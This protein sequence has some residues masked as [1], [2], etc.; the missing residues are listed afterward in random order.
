MVFLQPRRA[1]LAVEADG[2]RL[3]AGTQRRHLALGAALGR[4]QFGDPFVGQPQRG[5]RAVVMLVE[6]DLTGVEFT[7]AALHRLE[8]GLHLLGLR[9][10]VL[11]AAGQPRH[12]LV[13]RLDAGA[14]RVDL[15]CQ[16][17]QPLT[18]VGLGAGGG[19]VGT[20]GFGGDAL[21]LAQFGAGGL[22]PRSRFGQLVEQLPLLGGDLLGLGLQRVG[23]GTGGGFGLGVE[24]LGSL[25]GDAH[26]GADTFGQRRQ[27]KP[28]LLSGFRALTE[29]ADRRLVGV[30]LD[31]LGLEPGGQIV[32]FAAQRRLGLVGVLELGLAVHQI[33]GGQPQPSVAQVGL[34]GLGAAGHLG[35]PAERLELTAQ[36]GRQVRQPRQVGRHRVELADRLLL[37]LAVLEHPGGFLDERAPVLRAGLEDLG[38]LALA[39]DD[40]HLAADAGVATAAPAH[41]SNGNWCR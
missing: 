39:D 33:V 18:A 40:V 7:D 4:L 22:Q 11:D 14:H 12:G 6:T 26:R 32:V 27:R 34:D 24:V 3:D 29:A 8:L 5:H 1:V 30:Q 31:G 37:A 25:A 35:L 10:G 21:P 13:D 38:E 2:Q 17:G 20:F 19:H 36:L 15:A 41:P 28:G 23:I 9:R 16:P